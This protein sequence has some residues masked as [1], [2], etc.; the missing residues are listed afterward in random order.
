MSAH[1]DDLVLTAAVLDQSVRLSQVLR[2][3]PVVVVVVVVAVVFRAPES[4]R[5]AASSSS[6]P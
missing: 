4:N 6:S 3:E 2:G 5:V 1:D